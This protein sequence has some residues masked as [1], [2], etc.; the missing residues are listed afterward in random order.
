MSE[1]SPVAT[2]NRLDPTEFTATIGR[3]R[4][5]R[6]RARSATT[7]AA[8]TAAGTP[9]DDLPK[10]EVGKT[11]GG[12][13]R[14]AESQPRDAASSDTPPAPR[15]SRV[16]AGLGHT[17]AMSSRRLW[18]LDA[19][20]GLMLVLMTVTHLPTRFSD[21]LG[22]PFGFV[23][24][25]EGFVML[26]GVMAGMVYT[27]RYLQKGGRAGEEVMRFAFL[28]RVLTL[29]AI[30][31][32]LLVVLFTVMALIGVLNDQKALL[33]MIDFYLADPLTAV[34][35]SLLLIHNPPLLDILPMYIAFMLASPVLLAHGLQNT[36]HGWNVILAASIALWLAAQFGLGSWLFEQFATLT[37][38]RLPPGSGGAFDLLGWQFLWVLGLWLGS[39]RTATGMAEGAP[40]PIEFPR[41]MVGAAIAIA[42]IGFVWRHAV[43]QAPFPGHESLNLM[44]DKWRLGPLRLI[45]FFALM[46]LVLHCA[47]RLSRLPR[48]PALETM[49]AASLPVF[50]AHLVL[51]MGL[52]AWSG[53]QRDSRSWATDGAILAVCFAILYGVAW[54]SGWLDRRT[55][56]LRERAKAKLVHARPRRPRATVA[57][58]GV[59]AP[60]RRCPEGGPR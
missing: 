15:L 34:A 5:R 12:E 8:T 55:A 11:L 42:L 13:L 27:A 14:S 24:A 33:G 29:Y 56:R 43:G 53:D 6:P 41:W 7:T 48:V 58:P 38:S 59:S 54:T 9:G 22:Q 26:S 18:E 19:L 39:T 60:P 44:F 37:G 16:Q 46:T 40:E 17:A 35:A 3:G 23:S 21:P 52:L 50:V 31:A 1:T 28:K 20:R 4:S 10:T 25:A 51:A 30:Q 47:Q 45:G 49:G 2:S 57:N 36:K 32:A